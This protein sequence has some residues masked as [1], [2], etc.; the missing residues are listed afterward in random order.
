MRQGP[1]GAWIQTCQLGE[2]EG[3]KKQDSV[4][5]KIFTIVNRL[6]C[7]RL[8]DKGIALIDLQY[9]LEKPLFINIQSFLGVL[10]LIFGYFFS[11]IPNNKLMRAVVLR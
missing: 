4:L 6:V 3:M 9:L 11:N 8:N 5:K 10:V 2:R 1:K 7:D